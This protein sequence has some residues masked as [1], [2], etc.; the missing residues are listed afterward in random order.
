[1]F[2]VLFSLL[3]VLFISGRYCLDAAV[4]DNFQDLDAEDFEQL[5]ERDKCSLTMLILHSFSL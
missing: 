3:L 5:R 1:M 2:S 4:F